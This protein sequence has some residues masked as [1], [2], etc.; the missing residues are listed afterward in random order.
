MSR[1][2]G[3]ISAGLL[4]GITGLVLSLL[5]FGLHLEQEVGLSLL[6]KFRGTR[7]PPSEVLIVTIDKVSAEKLK[8]SADP[9]KW[10]RALHAG[11]TE[12]LAKRGASVIAFDIIFDEARS[13]EQDHLFATAIENAQCVVL[14]ELLKHGKKQ[15]LLYFF[16]GMLLIAVLSLLV[17]GH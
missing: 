2:I 16:S 4:T 8:T 15:V 7:E 9:E 10:P 1:F 17:H 14:G 11:L 13:E 3:A 12:N 6:F 5:P